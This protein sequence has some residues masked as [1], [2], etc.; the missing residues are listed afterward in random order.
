MLLFFE[1]GQS[2]IYSEYYLYTAK[3]KS[4]LCK[5]LLYK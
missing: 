5:V 2:Y 4:P 3:A 1:G